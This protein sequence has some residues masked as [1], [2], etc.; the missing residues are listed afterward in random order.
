MAEDP[1]QS[2]IRGDW[3]VVQ[4]PR[5]SGPKARHAP[6]LNAG[7]ILGLSSKAPHPEIGKA[8]LLF[9]TRSDI[10]VR[11]NLING[12]VDPSRKSIFESKEFRRF[13]PEISK[14]EIGAIHAATPWPV[15]PQ[16]AQLLDVL[17][18]NIV[19][20]LDNRKTTSQALIDTQREWLKILP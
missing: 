19:A 1:K 3:G 15:V 5:G 4:M 17:S 13:A 12:G 6:A 8:F 20:A 11:L 2:L 14:V 10:L 7:Y 18:S 9:A 16:M